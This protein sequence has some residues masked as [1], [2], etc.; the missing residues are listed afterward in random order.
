[1]AEPGGAE[2]VGQAQDLYATGGTF[3]RRMSGLS[4]A[5]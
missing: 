5:Q 2:W 3:R 4:D 1:M